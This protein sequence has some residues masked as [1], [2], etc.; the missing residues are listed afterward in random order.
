MASDPTAAAPPGASSNPAAENGAAK[1]LRSEKQ[2]QTAP[3]TCSPPEVYQTASKSAHRCTSIS[4]RLRLRTVRAVPLEVAAV[5]AMAAGYLHRLARLTQRANIIRA[6]Q[7]RPVV[8][9]QVAVIRPVHNSQ[10]RI[11]LRLDGVQLQRHGGNFATQLRL[12][13]ADFFQL[14]VFLAQLVPLLGRGRIFALSLVNIPLCFSP[15]LW[16]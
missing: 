10:Q 5:P 9:A 8:G 12:L 16:E 4:S 15:C 13:L 2:Q 1:S 6:R 3:G 7:L 14:L 11:P